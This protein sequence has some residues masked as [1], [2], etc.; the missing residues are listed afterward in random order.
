M[1]IWGPIACSTR[2][3]CWWWA[4]PRCNWTHAARNGLPPV[5]NLF[6]FRVHQKNL[7]RIY[8]IAK[9]NTEKTAK[10][11]HATNLQFSFGQHH[12]LQLTPRVIRLWYDPSICLWVMAHSVCPRNIILRAFTCHNF[13]QAIIGKLSSGWIQDALVRLLIYFTGFSLED[14][15]ILINLLLFRSAGLV[16]PN[17]CRRRIVWVQ[18]SLF[19]WLQRKILLEFLR[20]KVQDQHFSYKNLNNEKTPRH[21]LTEQKFN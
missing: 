21:L 8:E 17:V 3:C 7:P 4:S 1:G 16:S 2:W 10:I 9:T 5:L 13:K 15:T 12:T 6:F 18:T 19:R 14:M 20:R 11:S